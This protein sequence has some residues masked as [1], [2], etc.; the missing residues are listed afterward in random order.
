MN[1]DYVSLGLN[2]LPENLCLLQYV[3]SAVVQSF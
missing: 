1:G 2:S 3:I